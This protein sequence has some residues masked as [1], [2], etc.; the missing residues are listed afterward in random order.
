VFGLGLGCCMQ[1]LLLA[2]QSAL[3]PHDMGVATSSS[4]FSRQ[5]GGT[6][7]TA[8]F[9]SILFSTV[10]DRIANA[11]HTI[12]PTPAF[13]AALHDPAV[14]ADPANRP[15]LQAVAGA[16]ASGGGLSESSLNDSSFINHLDPRLARPFLVG[17]SDSMSTVFLVASVVIAIGFV[18][19][20]FLKELPL[21]QQ[22]ALAARNSAP[23]PAPAAGD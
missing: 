8:V 4:T 6:I 20:L 16:G 1:P 3:S 12:A 15:V 13:Q 21:P 19:M 14:L 2:A 7:G 17:F 10:G 5:M 18:I 22:S 23:A 9:L 11:F